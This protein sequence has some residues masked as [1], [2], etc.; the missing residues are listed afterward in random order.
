[1][2]DNS[3]L[4]DLCR[5][6]L[7]DEHIADAPESEELESTKKAIDWKRR[8][9]TEKIIRESNEEHEEMKK[10]ED[11]TIEELKEQKRK[12]YQNAKSNGSISACYLIVRELG[13][14]INS[15]KYEFLNGSL[16][17][18]ADDYGHYMSVQYNGK[19][20]CST[21]RTEEL[22]VPGEWYNMIEKLLPQAELKVNKRRRK[23]D[24]KERQEW[25]DKLTAP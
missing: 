21:H 19:L 15:S 11:M 6:N 3:D 20:V 4:L 2:N 8:H 10:L 9:L 7:M 12:W 14:S 5:L 18:F 16:N 24:D 13:S 17:I 23:A 22:F 25:I 1:M